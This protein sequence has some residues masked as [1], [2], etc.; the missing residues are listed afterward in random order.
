MLKVQGLNVRNVFAA[1]PIVSVTVY[2]VFKKSRELFFVV[3]P[4]T[5]RVYTVCLLFLVCEPRSLPQK[6]FI[7]IFNMKF[8]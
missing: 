8:V 7:N 3:R 1:K 4:G 6:S 5:S 2:T